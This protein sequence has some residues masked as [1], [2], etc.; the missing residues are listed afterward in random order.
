MKIFTLENRDKY[1][2]NSQ[3]NEREI[4]F[5]TLYAN[6]PKNPIFEGYSHLNLLNKLNK[7]IKMVQT[8]FIL[9]A[10]VNI[11]EEQK[12]IVK[13][14]YVIKSKYEG[15][16]IRYPFTSDDELQEAIRLACEVEFYIENN[17]II[18]KSSRKKFRYGKRRSKDQAIKLALEYESKKN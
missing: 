5:T 15:R 1:N 18:L 2:S 10:N 9:S 11:P 16:E 17:R 14:G 8:G 13:D 7:N 4:Y 12:Y 3:L 6:N